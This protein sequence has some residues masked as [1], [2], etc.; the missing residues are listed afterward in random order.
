MCC[1]YT[2]IIIRNMWVIW[3]GILGLMIA[4]YTKNIII[5]TVNLLLYYILN[6][7]NSHINNYSAHIWTSPPPLTTHSLSLVR[8]Y[9]H[10]INTAK[11]NSSNKNLSNYKKTTTNTIII[12]KSIKEMLSKYSKISK[13]PNYLSISSF[14]DQDKYSP[15][16]TSL[17]KLL[18]M[19][20]KKLFKY[21]SN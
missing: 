8:I 17:H 7:S 16:S 4:M 19:E 12:S 14:L 5:I 6:K 10:W 11:I 18:I 20:I 9:H 15:E 2:R 3:W 21:C 1:Q 13:S